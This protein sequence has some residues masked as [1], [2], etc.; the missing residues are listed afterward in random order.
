MRKIWDQNALERKA[1]VFFLGT[2]ILVLMGPF[3]TY[4]D[5]SLPVRFVYWLLIMLGIGL[6]M[7]LLITLCLRTRL[8]GNLNRA[9]RIAIGAVLAA[10]PGTAVTIFVDAVLRPPI[11]SDDAIL[12]IYWQVSVIGV[13]I[14]LVEFEAWRKPKRAAAPVSRSRLQ[15]RLPPE[16]GDDIISLSM[17]DHYVEVTTAL[18][19]HLILMRMSDAIEELENLPGAQTHRSHW[20]SAQHARKVVRNGSKYEVRL[21]DG[22][23]LPV[24]QTHLEETRALI[25]ER[26]YG[27]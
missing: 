16:L 21:S 2:A 8:L 25:K 24:S 12:M 26:K 19:Q 13:A 14:G 3:G 18:G 7:H 1:F 10:M 5:L 4:N 17:N 20:V 9:A 23:K 15:K 22:R 27:V 11:V 6:F